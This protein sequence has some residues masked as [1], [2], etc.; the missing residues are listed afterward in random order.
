M[1]IQENPFYLLNVNC[2]DDRRKIIAAA[3]EMSF[4]LDPGVCA[5]AQNSLL[6]MAKRLSC[7]LDWFPAENRETIEE[8][9]EHIRKKQ[10]IGVSSSD[11][12]SRLN[13]VRFNYSLLQPSDIHGLSEQILSINGQY[14]LLDDDSIAGL[15]NDCRTSAKMSEVSAEDL[16]QG[17]N[18]LRGEIRQEIS[19]GL[20]GLDDV[21]CRD[22]V[23]GLAEKL[24]GPEDIILSDL[25]DEYEIRVQTVLDEKS[26][27]IKDRIGQ[28]KTLAR[29]ANRFTASMELL[30]K[31]REWDKWA[32]PLQMKAWINGMPHVMSESLGSELRNLMVFLCNEKHEVMAAFMITSQMM[33]IFAESPEL[34]QRLQDDFDLLHEKI[35]FSDLTGEFD[36]FF[37]KMDDAGSALCNTADS[38]NEELFYEK[39]RE[40]ADM[41]QELDLSDDDSSAFH[42][43]IFRR[44]RKTALKLNNQKDEHDMAKKLIKWLDSEFSAYPSCAEQ[45]KHD[46]EKL[47]QI[48]AEKSAEKPGWFKRLFTSPYS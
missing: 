16:S 15:L 14:S 1:S 40:Q 21:S 32:Q 36:S 29:R 5:D 31:V 27:E 44:A 39:V 3:D 26:D 30:E 22:M 18:S 43:A 7:E 8:I 10:M 11:P 33:K 17:I 45:I 23:T 37:Q 38:K 24:T 48:E 13:A 4:E 35:R 2:R 41:L 34:L 25:I 9:R 19:A 6:N 12:L 46:Q 28:I 42:D 20:S 47:D